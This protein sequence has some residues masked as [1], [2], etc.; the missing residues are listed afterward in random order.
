MGIQSHR[1]ARAVW[2]EQAGGVSGGLEL[3]RSGT[4][5]PGAVRDDMYQAGRQTRPGTEVLG[6]VRGNPSVCWRIC[7][8]LRS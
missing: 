5:G 2:F 1:G 8:S 3:R 6:P 7:H 4:F